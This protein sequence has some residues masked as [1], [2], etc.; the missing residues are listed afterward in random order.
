M[1]GA[2]SV[3]KLYTRAEMTARL[4]AEAARC[5]ADTVPRSCV[6][7]YPEAAAFML[8]RGTL[9]TAADVVEAILREDGWHRPDVRMGPVAHTDDAVVLHVYW[10]DEGWTDR[11]CQ[12]PHAFPV[13]PFILV[14]PPLPHDWS[15]EGNPPRV[16]L[17]AWPAHL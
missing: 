2:T 1:A 9:C 16:R 6:G 7:D 5:I 15:G 3:H 8:R 14:G 13:E 10:A 4:R 17:P 11:E 12:G